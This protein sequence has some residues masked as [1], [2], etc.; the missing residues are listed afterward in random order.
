MYPEDYGRHQAFDSCKGRRVLWVFEVFALLVIAGVLAAVLFLTPSRAR[1]AELPGIVSAAV[2]VDN[3]P[4]GEVGKR[5]PILGRQRS[6]VDNCPGCQVGNSVLVVPD[7]YTPRTATIASPDGSNP[8]YGAK[9]VPAQSWGD[10][11]PFMYGLNCENG[12]CQPA[13]APRGGPIRD[14]LGGRRR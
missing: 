10:Y 6:R 4:A 9:I 2:H 14:W 8:A 3:N 13:T 1:G 11:G 7:A 5:G 12:S